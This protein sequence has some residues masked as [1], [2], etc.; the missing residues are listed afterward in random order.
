MADV[1]TSGY[2]AFGRFEHANNAVLTRRHQYGFA[3]AGK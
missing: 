1:S 2:L 3:Q